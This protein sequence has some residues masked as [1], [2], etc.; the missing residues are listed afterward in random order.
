MIA[1]TLANV[2]RIGLGCMRLSTDLDRDEERALATLHAALDAGVTTLDTAHAYGRDESELGHNERLIARALAERPTAPRPR[3]ITKCG[4]RRDGGAWVPDGRAGRIR[5]DARAS[6]EAL[7]RPLDLLLLH[8]PDPRTS[9]ATAARALARVHA[10]GLALR[11]GVS[12]VS[13]KQLEEVAALAP[14]AAIEMAIGAYDDLAVR[15][16]V[17]AYGLAHGLE[18]LAH[19][20]LGGPDRAA[21]LSRDRALAEI[22]GAHA[23]QPT[24]AELVLAYLLAAHPAI[25]PI[26][27]ARRPE[28]VASLVRAASLV[29]SE[30][31]LL[32][33][34][35]RFPVL[36]ALRRPAP[37]VTGGAE[38]VLLMGIPGAGK[39]AAAETYVARG[40]ERLNRD[41]LG[42]TLRGIVRLLDDRLRDGATRLVLDNTYVTRATRSDVLRAAHA[43]GATVRCVHFAT[44]VHEAERNIVT[45]MIARFGRVLEPEEIAAFG[46]SEPT[47]LTPTA[48]LRMVRDLEPPSEDEGFASVETVPFVRE[49]AASDLP[50]AITLPLAAIDDAARGAL[51]ARL[52]EEHPTTACVLVAWRPGIDAAERARIHAFAAAIA[53]S[54]GRVVEAAIC[55]HPGGPPTCWCRPPLPGS[56]LA[57]A[58]R[59]GVDVRRP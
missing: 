46:R 48:L 29:L 7:G 5:S 22:R 51:L 18:V 45:R 20:P 58:H 28:T 16:G 23:V 39:S 3:V 57:F 27:G 33:L 1:R 52:A 37:R 17:V 54:T 2:M 56:W 12:N 31:Q 40:Y 21:R 25:V 11:I 42:G 10:D 44:P 4:M 47:A 6:V 30:E 49:A 38:V 24:A 59:H 8:A 35:A 50:L 55:S 32:L 13:R 53:T 15:S 36:G 19:A 34:D 43:R 9:L 41:T 14:I 26:V